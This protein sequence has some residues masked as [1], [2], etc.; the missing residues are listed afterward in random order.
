MGGHAHNDVPILSVSTPELM[1]LCSSVSCDGQMRLWA[2]S[3][4]ERVVLGDFSG[5][6]VKPL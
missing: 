1:N 4:K 6:K 5:F 2:V 3:E